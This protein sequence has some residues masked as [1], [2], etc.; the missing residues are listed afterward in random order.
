MSSTARDEEQAHQLVAAAAG[1]CSKDSS[2]SSTAPDAYLVAFSAD[3]RDDANPLDWRAGKKWMVTDVLSATSFNRI[4]VSTI[5]AP[6]AA[7]HCA[8]ALRMGPTEAAMSM[9]V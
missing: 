6:R 2:S 7:H 5:M 1:L 8:R 9:S 3:R 4:M